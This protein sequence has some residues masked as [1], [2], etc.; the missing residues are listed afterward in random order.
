MCFSDELHFCVSHSEMCSVFFMWTPF[1]LC[2]PQWNELFSVSCE[3]HWLC[4]PQWNVFN[5]FLMWTP[6][7]LCFPQLNVFLR[8]T[9]L[10]KCV[11]QCFSSEFHFF[12]TFSSVFSTVKCVNYRFSSELHLF[13]V[14]HSEMGFTAELHLFFCVFQS[15]MCSVF[16]QWISLFLYPFFSVPHSVN[17][18]SSEL[19]LFCVCHSDMGYTGELHLFF[20]VSHSEMCILGLKN[21]SKGSKASYTLPPL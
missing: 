13:F 20:C 19:H 7:V 8:W 3:L 2:F 5:M 10:V 9:P 1:V 6:L 12:F 21:L 11:H 4:F 18:F 14:S 15:E 17:R 16:L